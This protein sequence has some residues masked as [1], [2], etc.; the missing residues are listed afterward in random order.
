MPYPALGD[1]MEAHPTLPGE[2]WLREGRE[3]L[4]LPYTL[5]ATKVS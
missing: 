2:S 3:R 5:Q 4:P 1:H